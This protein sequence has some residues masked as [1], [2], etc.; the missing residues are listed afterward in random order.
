MTLKG[1][2]FLLSYR[3]TDECDH[4]FL[5]GSP[6]ARGTMT[7]A[8]IRDV[9]HQAKELGTVDMVYLQCYD[10]GAGNSPCTWDDYFA[11][12]PVY[13]GLW[14]TNDTPSQVED[15]MNSWQTECGIT[16]GFMWLYDD[17][18]N[19]DL[20]EQYAAAINDALSS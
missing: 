3:C 20:V 14:D 4:C 18:D 2:H 12:I 19:S 13:P 15:H 9:L 6:Q 11:G 5:W 1:I 17:F 8:Q 10:G 16:G 7:L